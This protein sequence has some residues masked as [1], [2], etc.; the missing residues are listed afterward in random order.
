MLRMHMCS[1]KLHSVFS[2]R[3]QGKYYFYSVC[4]NRH[5]CLRPGLI[6]HQN[7]IGSNSEQ[8]QALLYNQ[9]YP[10]A[11]TCLEQ[12]DIC[13]NFLSSVIPYTLYR[14]NCN[15]T[16]ETYC[17]CQI[18]HEKVSSDLS[19]SG[20]IRFIMLKNPT[21]PQFFKREQLQTIHT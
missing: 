20:R 13:V 19:D 4:Q 8:V 16:V 15:C 1:V 2:T 5:R 12:P 7:C 11:S 14:R 18:I 6:L 10:R 9:F 3:D 21:T 17:I